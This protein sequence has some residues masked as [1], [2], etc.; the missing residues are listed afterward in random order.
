MKR[1]GLGICSV[2]ALVVC[3]TQ[4]SM[5]QETEPAAPEYPQQEMLGSDGQSAGGANEL[6]D[7][8]SYGCCG[9]YGYQACAS[10]CGYSIYGYSGYPAYWTAGYL[11]APYVD[12]CGPV[13]TYS[14]Y[15]PFSPLGYP[16]Y[17]YPPG[18]GGW[19]WAGYA[20]YYPYGYGYGYAGYGACGLSPVYLGW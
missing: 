9:S 17:A 11:W 15:V 13:F 20:P 10:A 19:G 4:N 12:Y 14:N 5:A 8:S 7:L 16:V 2:L 18:Y 1:L 6:A 3:L